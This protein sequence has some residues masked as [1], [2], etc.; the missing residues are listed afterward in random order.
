MK[1]LK[2]FAAGLA[3]VF[4]VCS[5]FTNVR[6]GKGGDDLYG[7][8]GTNGSNYIVTDITGQTEGVDYLCNTGS[9]VCTVTANPSDV[10]NGEVPM[11]KA[12]AQEINSIFESLH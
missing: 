7:V 12:T 6:P 9:S 10:S 8:T 4:A 3:L 2:F 1:K 11:S 5:A